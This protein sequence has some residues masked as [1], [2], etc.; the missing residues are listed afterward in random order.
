MRKIDSEA[1]NTRFPNLNSE[2]FDNL[3]NK[4]EYLDEYSM[5]VK[6]LLTYLINKTSIKRTEAEI[7]DCKDF[8]YPIQG[9]YEEEQDLY[10]YLCSDELSYFYIRNYIYIERLS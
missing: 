5:Y 7:K 4:G 9:P 1:Y 8:K 3:E 2:Y 10:Q 6:L